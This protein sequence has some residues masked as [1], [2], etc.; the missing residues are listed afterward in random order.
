MVFY[1]KIQSMKRIILCFLLIFS[2]QKKNEK[3]SVKSADKKIETSL[4]QTEVSQQESLEEISRAILQ[5]V[6]SQNYGVFESKIH[7]AKGVRFSMY[8]FV[9][10]NRDK[11]FTKE[12]FRKFIDSKIIFTWGEKDGSGELYKTTL[13]NY[14]S[15]WMLKKDFSS[16]KLSVNSFQASGNSL[17]NLREVYPDSKFVEFYLP[18]TDEDSKM[19][20][21]ALR[22]V[23]EKLDGIY[24][25]TGVINDQWTI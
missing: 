10:E 19:D 13:R 8:A 11:V 4:S 6:K 3:P 15:D 25:L 18:G 7:P 22:L 17:N 5:S 24:Y 1:R 9:D 16:G 23:F 21:F 14:L 2:C 20:W 12:D